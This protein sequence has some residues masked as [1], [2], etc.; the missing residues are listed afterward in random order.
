MQVVWGPVLCS[1]DVLIS[2]GLSV[3]PLHGGLRAEK[4]RHKQDKPV[5]QMGTKALEYGAAAVRRLLEDPA[6]LRGCFHKRP[7][8]YNELIIML[9]KFSGSA[10][11]CL[12][13]LHLGGIQS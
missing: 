2:V 3:L 1:K 9:V 10:V 12:S 11:A 4:F 13:V 7:G 5:F 8:C 6:S